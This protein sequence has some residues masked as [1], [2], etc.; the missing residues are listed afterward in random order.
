MWDVTILTGVLVS[1]TVIMIWHVVI[2]RKKRREWVHGVIFQSFKLHFCAI[3][4]RVNNFT[5][6]S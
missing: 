2:Q 1:R 5:W 4:F 6:L 3:P